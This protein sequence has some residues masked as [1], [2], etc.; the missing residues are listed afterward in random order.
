MCVY[1]RLCILVAGRVIRGRCTSR[2]KHSTSP[3]CT[4]RC[5]GH[6]QCCVH[7]SYMS[8]TYPTHT[9]ARTG[10]QCVCRLV[11]THWWPLVVVT[12]ITCV[13]IIYR[14][15]SYSCL[16]IK[17]YRS[18]GVEFF[19]SILFI[20]VYAHT[21]G[22]DVCLG[23]RKGRRSIHTVQHAGWARLVDTH[24]HARAQAMCAGELKCRLPAMPTAA[25]GMMRM[26][27]AR[28]YVYTP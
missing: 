7:S 20:C 23:K 28:A 2:C 25:D 1:I 4:T 9:R 24:T 12:P 8:T 21:G 22:G 16:F 3:S 18:T 13:S 10:V 19:S 17:S 11:T 6:R 15:Y 26:W 5:E 27:C 14:Y